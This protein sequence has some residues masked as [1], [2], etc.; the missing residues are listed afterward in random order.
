MLHV[1]VPLGP[2]SFDARC[3]SLAQTSIRADSPSGK[4]PTTRVPPTYLPIEV[5]K[6]IVRPDVAPEQAWEL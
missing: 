3:L 4:L 1:Q 6:D 2:H 5:L